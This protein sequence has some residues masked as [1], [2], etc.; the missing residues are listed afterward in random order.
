M[1]CRKNKKIQLKQKQNLVVFTG[2]KWVGRSRFYF[3]YLFNSNAHFLI[4]QHRF[5][6]HNGKRKLKWA[7]VSVNL[8]LF[9]ISLHLIASF[10][11]VLRIYLGKCGKKFTD[12]V[13]RVTV[14]TRL[15]LAEFLKY[16]TKASKFLL[17]TIIPKDRIWDKVEF[18][19]SSC[20][21]IC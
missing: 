10:C 1:I 21:S 16:P 6:I 3:I 11:F 5:C 8:V 18:L 13:G 12:R 19:N 14:S 20:E 4:L 15:F 2:R 17:R 7:T 9:F